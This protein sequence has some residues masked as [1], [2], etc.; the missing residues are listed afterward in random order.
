VELLAGG[1]GNTSELIRIRGSQSDIS[2][3]RKLLLYTAEYSIYSIRLDGGEPQLLVRARPGERFAHASFSPDNQWLLYSVLAEA[4]NGLYA[5]PLAATGLP[6][7]ISTR[8][9]S[10]VWR[11]DGKEILYLDRSQIMSVRVER[12]GNDLRIS[13]PESL[14]AVRAPGLFLAQ[15]ALQVSRD[16]SRIVFTQ[17][18]EQSA[19]AVIDVAAGWATGIQK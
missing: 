5:R 14:F 15:K 6:K 18:A 16:G 2:S 11:K 19:P 4:R 17:A 1:T 13:S 9:E 8:G 7:Q 3:D 10:P 12:T